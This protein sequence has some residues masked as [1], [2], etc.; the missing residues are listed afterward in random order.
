MAVR[1]FKDERRVGAKVMQYE[2]GWTSVEGGG[3]ATSQGAQGPPEARK[4]KGRFSPRASGGR[5]LPT[6]RF[7]PHE[8]HFGPLPSGTL[9][10]S[11]CCL[12]PL[13][14]GNLSEQ[15]Q[16]AHGGVVPP[17]LGLEVPGAVSSSSSGFRRSP[18]GLHRAGRSEPPT[19]L[20]CQPS[21]W[22]PGHQTDTQ[23]PER[24]W[25]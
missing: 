21:S 12:Q 22:A 11:L 5:N 13:G 1:S 18:P 8:T 9:R 17:G 2:T 14:W 25:R 23:A 24:P 19:L 10:I 20:T 7:Q 15:Q 6:P 16:E 3:R 4:C